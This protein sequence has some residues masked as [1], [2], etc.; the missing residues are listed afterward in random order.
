MT[1][2][3]VIGADTVGVDMTIVIDVVGDMMIGVG[4]VMTIDEEVMNHAE[5]TVVMGVAVLMIDAVMTIGG[6][7]TKTGGTTIDG[8]VMIGMIHIR[9]IVDTTDTGQATSSYV[10]L[11]CYSCW[12]HFGIV[13]TDQQRV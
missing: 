7:V 9:M 2:D 12:N 6:V 11:I 4:V 8:V 5:T 10:A 3:L 13:R 1:V